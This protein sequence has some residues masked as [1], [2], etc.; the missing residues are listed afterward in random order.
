M[1]WDYILDI[2]RKVEK[3]GKLVAFGTPKKYQKNKKLGNGKY[4]KR[5]NYKHDKPICKRFGLKS[6]C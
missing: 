1:C 5:E 3:M 6:F 2:G 4:P